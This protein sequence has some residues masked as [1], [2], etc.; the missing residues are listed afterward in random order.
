MPSCTIMALPQRVPHLARAMH[1][2][3]VEARVLCKY[4]LLELG[5]TPPGLRPSCSHIMGG[6]LPNVGSKCMPRKIFCMQC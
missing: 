4:I 5:L 2:I 1:R 3:L 6:M